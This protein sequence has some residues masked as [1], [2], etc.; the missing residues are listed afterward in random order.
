[1]TVTCEK[2]MLAEYREFLKNKIHLS[3][4]EGV[5]C[6]PSDVSPLLKPH[7]RDIVCWA[8]N[9]GRRAI[10]CAFG[11]GKTMMQL[12][13]MRIILDKAGGGRALIII[14]LGVRQEFKR[15]ALKLDID[16]T[17][18]RSI[19]EAQKD[20]IYLTNYETVR[21]GKLNRTNSNQ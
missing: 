21:E 3:E 7:Q 1:M 4:D 9:G 11:L 16:V 5:R 19:G 20:G 18:I 10:F 8:V 14:P 12:E 15:D 6:E 13:I 2:R 17:F